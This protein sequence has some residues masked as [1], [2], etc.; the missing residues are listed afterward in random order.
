MV[1]WYVF[2]SGE[3]FEWVID[4]I[5]LGENMLVDLLYVELFPFSIRSNCV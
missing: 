1:L 3:V 2:L 4:G 5:F